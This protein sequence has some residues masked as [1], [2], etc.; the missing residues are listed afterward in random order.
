MKILI[1]GFEP[2][3]DHKINPTMYL[4]KKLCEQDFSFQVNGIILP[5]S[6]SKSFQ[7]LENEIN[8]L[9]PDIVISFGL[10]EKRKK[11]N[12]EQWAQNIM[13]TK[14]ADNDGVVFLNEPIDPNGEESLPTSLPV[15]QM[16]SILETNNLSF[17]LSNSAGNYVC[18]QLMYKTI[19]KSQI[20][21]FKSGFVHIPSFEYL[22]K[23]Q[24]LK[25]GSV[26]L[27]SVYEL[28]K[29]I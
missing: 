23:N 7:L 3:A 11:I 12:F 6:Y 21:G 24:L 8:N 29:H 9:A 10:A 20:S 1:S 15:V 28:N 16:K 22:N 5:V 27:N 25:Y 19:Q 17:E 26:I 14:V 13:N 18:N 4:V 2:F